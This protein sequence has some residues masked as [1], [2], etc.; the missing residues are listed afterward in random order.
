MSL[1]VLADTPPSSSPETGG[2]RHLAANLWRTMASPAVFLP[3]GVLAAFL[4]LWDLVVRLSGSTLFPKPVEVVLGLAELLEHGVL[5]KYVVASLFRVTWGFTLAV[6][7]G[8]PAGL[9]L[10]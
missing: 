9:L 8:V 5:F 6:A 2:P 3:I 7:V 1:E 4:L 10:G